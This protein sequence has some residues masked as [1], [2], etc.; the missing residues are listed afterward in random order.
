MGSRSSSRSD[1]ER[2]A[3]EIIINSREKGV[4]QS[5]LWRDLNASSREGSRI[6]IKLEKK[7]LIKR[8]RELA[9]GR[10]T[11]RLFTDRMPPRIDSI[12]DSP[13]VRCEDF[14]RCGYGGTVSPNKCVKLMRWILK[15]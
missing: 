8:R 13:C 6:S 9:N 15:N 2:R 5:E 14:Y 11:Y 10:W 1:L 4:L 7:G 3:L 12:F